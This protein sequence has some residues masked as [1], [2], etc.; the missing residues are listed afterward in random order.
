MGW[1]HQIAKPNTGLF[2]SGTIMQHVGWFWLATCWIWQMEQL[3]GDSMPALHWVSE[4]LGST[5][6]TKDKLQM[7]GWQGLLR[8]PLCNL[9]NFAQRGHKQRE[10]VKW[11]HWGTLD[12][13]T[14]LREWCD[15]IWAFI[16]SVCFSCFYISREFEWHDCCSVTVA[17]F[18]RKSGG[19][20][21][22]FNIASNV[23][24]HIFLIFSKA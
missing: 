21:C 9:C 7:K 8:S 1:C 3:P 17:C 5:A 24:L 4:V 15:A 11:S 6:L 19:T 2:C 23:K 12:R 10:P 18:H 13:L 22:C 14:N 20:S 16:K